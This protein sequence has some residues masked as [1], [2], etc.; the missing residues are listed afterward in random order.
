MLGFTIF[1][2]PD[3][4]CLPFSKVQSMADAGA[5][6]VVVGGFGVLVGMT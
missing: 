1:T 5:D 3:F 4:P 6:V 2:E